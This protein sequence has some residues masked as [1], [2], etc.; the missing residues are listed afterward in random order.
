MTSLRFLTIVVVVLALPVVMFGAG[1]HDSLSCTGC[2]GIHNAKTGELIFAIDPNKKLV[3]PVTK[4][5]Y[6]GTTALCL[7][8]HAAEADGGMGIAPVSPTHSHPFGVVPNPKLA[9]VPPEALRDNKLGC[10]GCHN[11]HPSNTNYKYLRVDTSGGSKMENFC[12]YCH[13][14]EA[15]PAAAKAAMASK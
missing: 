10:V 15:G 4:Q 9:S 6:T 12:A 8:C 3:N 2:H 13:S 14:A 1:P 11:P 7:G 5:T